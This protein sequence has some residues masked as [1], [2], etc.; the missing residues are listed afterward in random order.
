MIHLARHQTIL[1]R[2]RLATLDQVRVFQG[3]TIKAHGKGR[4]DILRIQ[5]YDET[6]APLVL[7]LKRT[8]RAYT[9]D[10]LR[11]LL[12]H[13]RVHSISWQ[14]WENS[15]SLHQAG[16]KTAPLVAYGEDCGW[17]RERFSFLITES[18]EGEG[19]LEQFLQECHHPEHRHR[20]LDALARSI[21]KMHEAGLAM[22]D[23][24]T[25]HIFL[26]LP[27]DQPVFYFIDMA[28]LDRR[29]GGSV[30]GRVRDLAALNVTAP[31]RHV[32]MRERLRFLRIYY[33]RIDRKLVAGISARMKRLLRRRKYAGFYKCADRDSDHSGRLQLLKNDQGVIQSSSLAKPSSAESC[34]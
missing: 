2:L 3:E 5:T 1:Q 15:L 20:V 19:T 28:R 29:A 6:G 30:S 34:P 14:E 25:R 33:G 22:P 17:L 13:G 8:W 23:L 18:V 16:L 31:L 24:F 11:T 4:R 26:D 12:R 21:R 27:G 10:G 32:S 9:K 7:Y